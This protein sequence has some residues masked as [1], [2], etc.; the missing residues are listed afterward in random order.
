MP[1]KLSLFDVAGCRAFLILPRGASE[2]PIPWVWYAPTFLNAHPDP[3]HAWMFRQFLE[4]G[5]AIA[6]I[7]V[8]ESFGSPKGRQAYTAFFEAVRKEHRLSDRP[9]LLPQS[10]GG[11]MLYNWAVEHPRSVACIA[12]IYTV[13]DLRSYPG[14]ERACVAYG[15]TRE[16]LT[17]RLPEH[18]PLDRLAAL[19]EADVPILHVHGDSDRVVP[20]EKNSGELARRYQALGGKITL[21]VV[22]ERGHQVCPEFF[23]RQELV[24]FVIAHVPAA[25]S[26]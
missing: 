19:A 25:R 26:D 20:L 5:I 3:S 1:G 17:R 12:G 18:N 21:I 13:C 4:H 24:D 14:I 6:G 2:D 16:E 15:M 9:G 23:Q 8:G 7:E 11:L 22:P 10:R